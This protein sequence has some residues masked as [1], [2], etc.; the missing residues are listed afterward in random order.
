MSLDKVYEKKKK[1]TV[2]V[3]DEENQD[4]KVEGKVK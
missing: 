3:G 2:G 4:V 1:V